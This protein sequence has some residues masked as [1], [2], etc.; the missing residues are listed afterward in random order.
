MNTLQI[1]YKILHTLDQWEDAP[2]MGH[3]ISP[4]K[5]DISPSEWLGVMSLLIDEGCISGVRF[6][7]DIY[8]RRTANI[9]NAHITLKGAEYLYTNEVMRKYSGVANNV[10]AYD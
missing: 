2:Y 7:R 6:S 1:A 8:G 4:K 3:L 9:K 5:L 10:V